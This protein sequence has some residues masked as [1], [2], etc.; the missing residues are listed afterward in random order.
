MSLLS[1]DSQGSSPASQF[2]GISS[3]ALSLLYVPILRSVH[4]YWK[5]HSL[6]IWTFISNVM[7]LLF[8][9]LFRFVIAFLLR[10]K[11]LLI[12]WLQSPSMVIFEPRKIKFVT[13]IFSPSLQE[14]PLLMPVV[15]NLFWPGLKL[16][17]L[18][19]QK[20][21]FAEQMSSKKG[22]WGM[23]WGWLNPLESKLFSCS[24]WINCLYA[25]N[26]N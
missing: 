26:A 19:S 24:G 2:E 20:K 13:F 3:L 21:T 23:G 25:N 10:S 14:P 6:N 5:N 7:F 4:D 22:N 9:M 16:T 15:L 17:W 1:K 12:S 18:Q 8:N 11:H